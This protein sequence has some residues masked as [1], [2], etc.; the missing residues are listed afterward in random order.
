MSVE[1]YCVFSPWF[2]TEIPKC[3]ITF[4][5]VEVCNSNYVRASE[6]KNSSEIQIVI[7]LCFPRSQTLFR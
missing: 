4:S 7:N 3:S 1:V 5:E 6:K 2:S